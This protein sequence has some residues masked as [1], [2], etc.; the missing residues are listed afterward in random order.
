MITGNYVTFL[1]R[2]LKQDPMLK[3]VLLDDHAILREGIKHLLNNQAGLQVIAECD[4]PS[5]LEPLLEQQQ[6]DLL[7]I[8]LSMPEGGG[9][10]LLQRI[11]PQ[12]PNL[13]LIVLSMHENPGYVSKALACGV[14]AYVTKARAA[15]ELILA[16]HAVNN[17][18]RYLSSDIAHCVRYA[19]IRL[20]TRERLVLNSLLQGKNL[21]V[22][23]A[24]L[25]ITDK[26]LYAHRANIMQ[27]IQAR[28]HAELQELALRLGLV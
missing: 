21:K 13:K 28:N 20:S 2:F 1:S 15:E 14:N 3:I 26:T 12:Y 7:L 27:K 19:D 18:N 23:A 10:P 22:I 24:E 4:R 16:I 6:P 17:G 25:G 11:R 5:R 8:D 9:F